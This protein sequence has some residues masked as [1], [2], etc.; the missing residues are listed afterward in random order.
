MANK[1]TKTAGS[2]IGNSRLVV[3]TDGRKPRLRRDVGAKV[4][5]KNSGWNVVKPRRSLR[6]RELQA[7]QSDEEM[8]SD[9]SSWSSSN[10][11]QARKEEAD[12]SM[13]QTKLT[14]MIQLM[15]TNGGT[16]EVK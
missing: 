5:A 3:T 8:N 12:K 4:R 1:A 11:E 10:S 13:K 15:K 6:V 9:T 14:E 2:R 16:S 7:V